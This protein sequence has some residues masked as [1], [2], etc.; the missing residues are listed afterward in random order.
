MPGEPQRSTTK[1]NW[2]NGTA[3]MATYVLKRPGRLYQ[4]VVTTLPVSVPE[5]MVEN[6]L[7][8][9]RDDFGKKRGVR[10]VEEQKIA[11]GSIP[12]RQLLVELPGKFLPKEWRLIYARLYLDGRQYVQAMVNTP[13]KE[14]D[15][16]V[17]RFL[18]SFQ[19]V[20]KP[21]SKS[22]AAVQ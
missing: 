19:A 17:S 16:D 8:V 11:L 1:L 20:A 22:S 4:V 3:E 15:P 10:Q 7:N 21:A 13:S 6:E 2:P 5:S 12:G 18:D 14:M 9:F